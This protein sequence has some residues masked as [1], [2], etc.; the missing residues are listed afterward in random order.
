MFY[1]NCSKY[2]A[3]TNYAN[4]ISDVGCT[5]II[6]LPTRIGQKSSTIIDHIYTNTTFINQITPIV[7]LE[8]IFDHLR[9]VP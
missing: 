5:L 4:L 1:A 6:N 9:L 8:D 2:T 7:F 3:I